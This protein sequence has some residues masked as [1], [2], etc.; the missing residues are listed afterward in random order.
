MQKKTTPIPNFSKK[1]L[2]R[3]INNCQY[4]CV[5]I[6]LLWKS[7]S[8]KKKIFLSLI[9]ILNNY[10]SFTVMNSQHKFI[11]MISKLIITRNFS[12]YTSLNIDVHTKKIFFSL[13]KNIYKIE[14][15]VFL[16]EYVVVTKWILVERFNFKTKWYHFTLLLIK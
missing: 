6:I 1:Y 4:K 14:N 16:T 11:S 13:N 15:M 10:C 2:V 12:L 7:L 9:F 8:E 5:N 3:I